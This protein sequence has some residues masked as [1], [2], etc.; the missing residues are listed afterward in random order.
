MSSKN[1]IILCTYNE[2]KYIENTISELEK[3]I[4]SLEL[5]IV[6]DHSTDGT[7]EIITLDVHY[8]MES[9]PGSIEL[10]IHYYLKN[11]EECY[12]SFVDYKFY[13]TQSAEL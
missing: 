1:S 2:G 8:M 11:V 5:V 6:D 7:I 13:S 4:S 10:Y 9:F 12:P 3:N